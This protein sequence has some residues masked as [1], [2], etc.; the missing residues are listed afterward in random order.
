METKQ[1]IKENEYVQAVEETKKPDKKVNIK[2]IVW[3]TIGI[4]FLVGGL[5]LFIFCRQLFGDEVGDTVL[6]K[7]VKNG[8]IAI[9][10]F[11][12]S[13]AGALLYSLII[14][15]ILS[16]ITII[17]H[18]IIN[19]VMRHT[20]RSR[21]IGSLLKSLVKYL[22]IVLGICF[23]LAIWGVNV[24]GI[25]AGVGVLG[26][27]I[28][29]GCKTLVNDIVSG[30]F[31]VVD[32]YFQVGEKVEIDG[33]TGNISNI[34]LRTTKIK[35]W[36]GNVKSINNSL[37]TS[38]INY[39]RFQS[40]AKVQIDVSY[41]EDLRHVEGL[42]LKNLPIIRKRIPEL[43]G[44]ITYEGVDSF[45]NCGLCLL[46][47]AKV[48]ESNRVVASR[49]LLREL[50][51][52][53]TDNNII[54]PYQQIVVN[55][56]DPTDTLKATSEDLKYVHNRFY[57]KDDSDEKKNSKKGHKTSLIETFKKTSD[58]ASEI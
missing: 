14:I 18:T 17:I 21:T 12:T 19:I 25:F 34:G 3:S 47:N 6:G 52:F 11:F 55:A 58:E 54:I 43:E 42:L 32:N 16:F 7:D 8:L 24:V 23:V 51:L 15:G 50:Y 30:F 57:K 56:P 31:I 40:I 33:F 2:K 5:L 9:G 22:A 20:A 39:S 35:S 36:D 41:N 1:E 46:F 45:S 37:I 38:V 53:F 48:N 4:L 28:G 26:L 29:L 44:D 13:N 27:I 49:K 10:V